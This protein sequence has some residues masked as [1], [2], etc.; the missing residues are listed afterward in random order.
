MQ[1][2]EWLPKPSTPNQ[3][4][5]CKCLAMSQHGIYPCTSQARMPSVLQDFMLPCWAAD[6]MSTK[7]EDTPSKSPFAM[8]FR[9][10]YC[11]MW[12]YLGAIVEP[13]QLALPG[14][15]RFPVGQIG[16]LSHMLM[17]WRCM[18][19]E[20]WGTP[21]QCFSV[22]SQCDF[23]LIVKNYL[24]MSVRQGPPVIASGWIAALL[25]VFFL[26]PVSL[27]FWP[28]G[29][30]VPWRLRPVACCFAPWFVIQLFIV[31]F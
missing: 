18:P 10:N 15:R 13:L 21:C 25:F 30:W 20:C 6:D 23:F 29:T 28:E 24:A 27:G 17:N 14:C 11:R 1:Y 8:C 16:N 26:V 9:W 2:C 31:S 19:M 7:R 3:G 4:P 22:V 12:W 5:P